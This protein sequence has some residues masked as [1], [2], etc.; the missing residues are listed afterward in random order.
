MS[1]PVSV[2]FL[3]LLVLQSQSEVRDSSAVPRQASD[4]R[5]LTIRIQDAGVSGSNPYVGVNVLVRAQ[6]QSWRRTTGNEGTANFVAIPCG[7]TVSVKL[8]NAEQPF[9]TLA[10][11]CQSTIPLGIS[12]FVASSCRSRLQ[13][14]AKQVN[15]T[16]P[17][18]GIATQRIQFKK[19]TAASVINGSISEGGINSYLLTAKKGQ[20]MNIHVVPVDEQNPVLF[21]VYLRR[22]PGVYIQ[23]LSAKAGCIA[24]ENVKDFMGTLPES[25]DYVISVYADGGIGRYFLDVIIQ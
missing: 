1:I 9:R 8:L 20:Q 12:A 22:D 14:I 25:G 24:S 18:S 11:P 13:L 3:A 19:C 23:A 21:D 10:F 6:N 15:L 17:L 7:G 4:S 2:C 16:K 5:D